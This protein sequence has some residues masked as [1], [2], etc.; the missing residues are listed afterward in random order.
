MSE[1]ERALL[2]V[3]DFH[4]EPILLSEREAVEQRL[5]ETVRYWEDWS[6]TCSYDGPWRAE[7]LRSVLALGLCVYVPTGA[8]VAA[9]TTSL[10]ERIGGSRNF[11]YRYGWVRDTSFALEAML[12]LGFGTQV[13]GTLSWLLAASASTH[14]HLRPFFKLDGS[15]RPSMIELPLAGYRGSQPVNEGN[16]AESQ[17]QLGNYGDLF[18]TAWRYVRDGNGLDRASRVRLAEVADFVCRIW[19][20]P[21]SG[22]WE[23]SEHLDYTQSKLACWLTLDRALKLADAGELPD[24]SAGNWRRARAELREYIDSNCWS[25][26][27]GAYTR[28]AGTHELDAAVLLAARVGYLDLPDRRMDATIAALREELG[29]GPLLYRYSGMED[30]EGAFLACSFW[31]VEA[32]ARSERLDE[33][34][35]LM[36]ELVAL[37]NDVGLLSE[38]IDPDS[39]ELLGNIPQALSHLTLINAAEAIAETER[40]LSGSAASRRSRGPAR[41]RG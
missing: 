8:M 15:Y 23:L 5:D 12:S 24:G 22:I 34:A 19:R 37:S 31:L 17:L 28:A 18:D 35:E 14:P 16:S 40:A 21:D 3:A 39:H 36:D 33:A 30:E 6:A 29:R 32:L 20:N 9:P 4:S 10:P 27:R 13:H 2:S 7:V 26:S 41:S 1:G 11:D 38:E 25:E